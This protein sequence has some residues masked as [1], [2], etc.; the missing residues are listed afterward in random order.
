MG[1]TPFFSAKIFRDLD[2]KY[3]FAFTIMLLHHNSKRPYLLMSARLWIISIFC[4]K[5]SYYYEKQTNKQIIRENAD[6]EKQGKP[7]NKEINP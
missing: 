4:Q 2:S 1:L 5:S 3:F 6:V 7:N